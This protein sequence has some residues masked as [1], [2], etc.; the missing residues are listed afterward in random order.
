MGGTGHCVRFTKSHCRYT[1]CISYRNYLNALSGPQSQHPLKRAI[2]SSDVAVQTEAVVLNLSAPA[3]PNGYRVEL[4]DDQ[5]SALSAADLA[6]I[7]EWSQ[8]I[9]SD[10]NLSSG[11]FGI[12]F[13][14]SY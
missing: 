4:N 2:F 14:A 13:P 1:H 7:L 9:S 8:D 3:N 11:K 5:E 10:I 12:F 6:S